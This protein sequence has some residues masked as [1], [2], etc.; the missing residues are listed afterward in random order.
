[1]RL[2]KRIFLLLFL[3]IVPST[4]A[5]AKS[6][7][8]LGEEHRNCSELHIF[9]FTNHFQFLYDPV[10]IE[11]REIY[12]GDKIIK[13][14]SNGCFYFYHFKPGTYLL[15][16]TP[17]RVGWDDHHWQIRFQRDML[18]NIKAGEKKEVLLIGDKA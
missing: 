10:S 18:I 6:D 12:T 7:D 15:R 16:A 1:V 8:P 2:S 9:T 11:L 3:V 14:S 5:Q 4:F 13:R 17:F